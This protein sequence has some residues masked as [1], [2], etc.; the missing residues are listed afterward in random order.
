MLTSILH[1][2]A[3]ERESAEQKC[4]IRSMVGDQY[5]YIIGKGIPPRSIID[6]LE[7][8]SYHGVQ[9]DPHHGFP[10]FTYQ[11]DNPIGN[12]PDNIDGSVSLVPESLV[13]FYD[14]D[15]FLY[16]GTTLSELEYFDNLFLSDD[17][18]RERPPNS[19]SC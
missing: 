8:R 12:V 3:L 5:L 18:E 7:P 11:Y 13:R 15:A 4:E 17:F 19:K 2:R 1:E 14:E 10:I 9:M 16:H 6:G